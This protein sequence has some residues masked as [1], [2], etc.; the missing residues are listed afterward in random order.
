MV[1]KGFGQFLATVGVAFIVENPS[2]T[3]VVERTSFEAIV[4]NRGVALGKG[5]GLGIPVLLPS[6]RL[7]VSLTSAGARPLAKQPTLAAERVALK[8]D[9]S[10]FKAT[11]TITSPYKTDARMAIVY[12]VAYDSTGAIIGGGNSNTMTVPANGQVPVEMD[13]VVAGKPARVELYPALG[14]VP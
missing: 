14:S 13:L 11:G 4:Y 3:L 12:A 1:A 10:R 7:G 2:E 9:G 5:S 8:A 6:Q